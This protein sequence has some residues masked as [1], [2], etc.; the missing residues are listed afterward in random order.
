[1]S[2]DIFVCRFVNAEQVRLEK[3]AVYEILD[4]YVT[5]RDPE[6]HF[7]QLK[8]GDADTADIYLSSEDSIMIRNFGGDRMMNVISKL[9]RRL[10]A[11][12]I[13]P[14]GTVILSREADRDTCLRKSRASGSSS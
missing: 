7:L 11:V 13:L 9:F 1:M 12:L 6:H 14:G 8:T 5:E 10:E 3:S 2:Y 4:A